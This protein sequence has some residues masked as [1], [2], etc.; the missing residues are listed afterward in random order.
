M[1]RLLLWIAQGT[2]LG[3][4]PKAPGTVG[5][6]GGFPLTALLLWPGNFLGVPRRMHF[7]PPHRRPHLRTRRTHTRRKRSTLRRARRNHRH[8]HLLPRHLRLS[9][10]SPAPASPPS[11]P[12]TEIPNWGRVGP[13][14]LRP[15]PPLR[16]L[17]TRPHQHH[18]NPPQ[19]LGR[20][21]G[22]RA[23]RNC[24]LHNPRHSVLYYLN[25]Q[26]AKA[27]RFLKLVSLGVLVAWRF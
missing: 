1:D 3:R 13:R 10:N 23:G 26:G 7:A 16:H 5:T 20:N 24:R 4:V 18:P 9:W 25:R 12:I 17:E 21:H 27:P 14:R 6:L 15:L 2:W 8:P 19:R 11:P 22:R